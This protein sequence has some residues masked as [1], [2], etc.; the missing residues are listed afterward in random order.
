MGLVAVA[1][2]LI[3]RSAREDPHAAHEPRLGRA[4]DQQHLQLAVAARVAVEVAQQDH[5]GRLAG[6]R[7]L[8][9]VEGLARS[10]PLVPLRRVH[11]VTLPAGSL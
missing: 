3:D 10:R 11:L 4:L 1:L 9:G 5:A 6:R 2:A 7:G 8:P